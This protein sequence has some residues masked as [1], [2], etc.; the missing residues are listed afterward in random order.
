MQWF[1]RSRIP[2]GFL[3]IHSFLVVLAWASIR[4][5]DDGETVIVWVLFEKIDWP[6]ALLLHPVEGNSAFGLQIFVLG[7][8]QWYFIGVAIEW[9]VNRKKPRMSGPE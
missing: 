1:K 2:I 8:L 3:L 7:G 4:T 5:S 9:L 6:S